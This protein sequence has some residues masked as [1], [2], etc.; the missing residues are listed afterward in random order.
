MFI[1]RFAN[2]TYMYTGVGRIISTRCSCVGIKVPL[3]HQQIDDKFVAHERQIC[4]RLP[5]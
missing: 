4:R 3:S 5:P 1:Y 2:K